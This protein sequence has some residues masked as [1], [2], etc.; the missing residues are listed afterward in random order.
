[1]PVGIAE[2]IIPSS[3]GNFSFQTNLSVFGIRKIGESDWVLLS[4][5]QRTVGYYIF[6][7][8]VEVDTVDNPNEYEYKLYYLCRDG[9]TAFYY[10]FYIH[11]TSFKLTETSGVYSAVNVIT[12][13]NIMSVGEIDPIVP[14]VTYSQLVYPVKGR[15]RTPSANSVIKTNPQITIGNFEVFDDEGLKLP[16]AVRQNSYSYQYYPVN[17]ISSSGDTAFN[18]P[19]FF[20][21]LLTVPGYAPATGSFVVRNT[22]AILAQSDIIPDPGT[23]SA[24]VN[25]IMV[26]FNIIK[27]GVAIGFY[28][29]ISGT[30]INVATNN[31]ATVSFQDEL[32]IV[33]LNGETSTVLTIDII[34]PD[35]TPIQ[36]V[37]TASLD[38][39]IW[40]NPAE[41]RE[42]AAVITLNAATSVFTIKQR[43]QLKLEPGLSGRMIATTEG[44]NQYFS[45]INTSITPA[46]QRV[47][48]QFEVINQYA[49]EYLFTG[50]FFTPT[51]S[52][53]QRFFR[54]GS[55]GM[56]RVLEY[57]GLGTINGM[58]LGPYVYDFYAQTGLLFSE[59][60][61]QMYQAGWSIYGGDYSNINSL[62]ELPAPEITA[63][64]AG[65]WQFAPASLGPDINLTDPRMFYTGSG[66][67]Y[68]IYETDPKI[69]ELANF[70]IYHNALYITLDK[71]LYPLQESGSTYN[72][73]LQLMAY[74]SKTPGNQAIMNDIMVQYHVLPANGKILFPNFA[75][76]VDGNLVWDA[77]RP[78]DFGFS[79]S[80]ELIFSP[81]GIEGYAFEDLNENGFWDEGEP[82][83][84]NLT[85]TLYNA[86]GNVSGVMA[87]DISGYYLFT[88]L[89][90]GSYFVSF[91]IPDGYEVTQRGTGLLGND[92]DQNGRS[93]T[94]NLLPETVM[95]LNGGFRRAADFLRVYYDPNGATSGA[96]PVDSNLYQQGYIVTVL[97]NTGGLT[98]QGYRF[99]GWGTTP[100]GGMIYQPGQV[101]TMPDHDVTLYAIW[102]LLPP[103][104]LR[105]YYDPNGATSGVVPIDSNLYQQGNIVT[106]LGNTG[107]LARQGYTFVGWGTTPNGGTIYQAGQVFTMPGHDVTLYAIW[108]PITPTPPCPPVSCCVCVC[109]CCCKIPLPC[110]R[111]RHKRC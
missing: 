110:C 85:V 46:G 62:L 13:P 45:E 81:T 37:L 75:Y 4:P 17:R 103:T 98:R 87:T 6:A 49:Q 19:E 97:G 53:S 48:A 51:N 67:L 36:L 30:A 73:D 82:A 106:V 66:N 32:L 28:G 59:A 72:P 74:V 10:L 25:F 7:A 111:C 91:E 88:G 11:G 68:A 22:A 109:T 16:T 27:T 95:R 40:D 102:E 41:A 23:A 64:F 29:L 42:Q 43:L 107:G 80:F 78:S 26:T 18:L 90:I 15:Y 20:R 8:E 3:Q 60:L 44:M 39:V 79:F 94:I 99:V 70:H 77:Y 31:N 89:T 56:T 69:I 50:Y 76:A 55:D 63:I 101:F 65:T 108:E 54:V 86:S 61:L 93:D 5:S 14:Q 52:P 84:P 57:L 21:Y 92:L 24:S 35:L 100:A 38:A 58:N 71:T 9:S 12:E 1:M 105:V 34:H 83:I 2:W 104:Y 96:V 47:D 33:S